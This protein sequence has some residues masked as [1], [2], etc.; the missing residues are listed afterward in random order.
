MWNVTLLAPVEDWFLQ[1]GEGAIESV[2]NAIDM[3][4][5]YGPTLGRPTVDRVKK[6]KL[7]NLKELRPAATN[8]RILFAFDP[9]RR[10]ILLV[11][12]D[13]TGNWNGWYT[14]NIPVAEQ[15]YQGWLDGEYG[16][17]EEK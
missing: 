1:L 4:E 5:Q 10:A 9:E 8:I 13:K 3:L 15:R 12:G 14:E 6:S 17:E 7:H 16:P 2:A 11:A